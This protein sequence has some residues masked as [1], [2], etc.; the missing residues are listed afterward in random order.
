LGGAIAQATDLAGIQFRILNQSKGPAVRATRAQADRSLY[1]AAIRQ[2]VLNQ[3]NLRVFQQP[4]DDIIL[5]GDKVVGARTQI[6]INFYADAV[7]LTVGTFLSG[8]IHIGMDSYT[9]G[10]AGDPAAI[11]LAE[12]LKEDRKS[13]EEGRRAAD[14]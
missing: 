10:R 14:G 7:I 12:R 11:T 9:G 2:K 1:R 5:K 4:V 13:V 6:G 3:P 8:R